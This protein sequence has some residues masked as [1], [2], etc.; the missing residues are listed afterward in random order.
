VVT[1]SSGAGLF[2]SVSQ[3]NYSA[4]KAGIAAF[5][6]VGAAELGRYNIKLNGIAP[7]ARSRMTEEAFAE[8]MKKPESGFD[9]MDPANVSPLVVWLGSSAC[10]IS[11]RMFE[12]AGGQ[13]SVADGWQHGHV[14]DKGAR[15]EPHEVGSIV[16]DLVREAPT[17]APVYGA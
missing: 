11:G 12:I 16:A 17:P 14:F 2:G 7:S 6:I 1:T 10:E 9:A 13:I 4:A 3:A 8:M 15:L 5:T